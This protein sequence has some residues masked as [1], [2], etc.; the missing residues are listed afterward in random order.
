MFVASAFKVNDCLANGSAASV[1]VYSSATGRVVSCNLECFVD[2]VLTNLCSCG[3]VQRNVELL[4]KADWGGDGVLGCEL[5]TGLL[6]QI[7]RDT[8]TER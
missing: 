6:H 4:P 3:F 8:S 5:A 7:H 1:M 2:D